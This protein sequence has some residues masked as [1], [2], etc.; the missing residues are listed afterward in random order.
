MNFLFWEFRI[1]P[2]DTVLVELDR[3]ANVRLM[4]S[5]NFREYQT[6]RACSFRG[7]LAVRS[8]ALLVPPHFGHWYVVVDLHGL[9]GTVRASVRLASR[10]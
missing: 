8:P 3:Q 9:A 4:D 5:L 6:G 10:V 1:G 7:G 2:N